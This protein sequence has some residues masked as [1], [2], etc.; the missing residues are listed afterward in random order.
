MLSL[1]IREIKTDNLLFIFSISTVF[2]ALLGIVSYISNTTILLSFFIFLLS[3]LF[4]FKGK[5]IN[6]WLINIISVILLI[7]PFLGFSIED[8]VL[9]STEALTLITV[10]RLLGKKTLREYFQIY[11]LSMLLLV[12][13]TLF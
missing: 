2:I 8:I 10:I 9:P 3:I 6:Q 4:Y 11:L 1:F 7:Y 13:S 12:A 5:T